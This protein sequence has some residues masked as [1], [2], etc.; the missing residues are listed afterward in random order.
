[1]KPRALTGKVLLAMFSLLVLV[2]AACASPEQPAA[3]PADL[4]PADVEPAVDD[5]QEMS[6]HQMEMED[7]EAPEE[8]APE[9]D[10]APE[11]ALSPAQLEITAYVVAYHWGF[12]IFDEDGTELEQLRAAPGATV[13]IVA[14]NDHASHALGQLP[15]PVAAGIRAANWH[16]RAHHDV[17]MGRI[18]DP[19]SDAGES[20]SAVL[21]AAHDGHSHMGPTPDHGLMV[22]GIGARAFLDAHAREPER[23]VFTVD[24][25]GTYEF[26]CTEECGWGH[27]YQRWEML[28]VEA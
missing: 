8:G 18:P 6:D 1:M 9:G 21:A 17:E 10:S 27:D 5:E 15:E 12:A 25:E 2:V 4:E 26:R 23:L 28:V 16:E 11:A 22:T 20:L 19:E 24:E 3:G 14:V 7:A 13:E